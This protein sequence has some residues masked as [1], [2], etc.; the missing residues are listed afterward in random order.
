MHIIKK[1]LCFG[2]V[3][4]PYV[5]HLTSSLNLHSLR[6]IST[7]TWFQEA[8]LESNQVSLKEKK[9]RV[10][11]FLVNKYGQY[12]LLM[13]S[14]TCVFLKYE[15]VCVL[16]FGIYKSN[17]T[18]SFM[19]YTAMYF[20]WLPVYVVTRISLT[21][22]R[23]VFTTFTLYVDELF[24]LTRFGSKEKSSSRRPR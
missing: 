2:D 15:N 7:C 11:R 23:M 10:P 21:K 17:C 24:S 14:F 1:N 6:L 12:A 22:C 4:I 9:Y 8:A 3:S 5:L 18:G 13:F 16:S 19:L 20:G